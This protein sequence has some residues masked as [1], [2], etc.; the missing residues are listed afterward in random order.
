MQASP[1]LLLSMLLATS[2]NWVAMAS[3]RADIASEETIVIVSI[4][5][6]EIFACAKSEF[7]AFKLLA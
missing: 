6:N 5:F 2:S 1:L 7:A 4:L 3:L